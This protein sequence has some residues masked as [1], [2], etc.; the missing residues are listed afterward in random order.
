MMKTVNLELTQM[1]LSYLK[2]ILINKPPINIWKDYHE[3]ICNKIDKV[4]TGLLKIAEAIRK[5]WRNK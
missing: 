1:E 3:S 2:M 4:S 5:L